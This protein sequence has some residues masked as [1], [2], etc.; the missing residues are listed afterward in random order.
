MCPGRRVVVR[1]E[2]RVQGVGFRFAAVRVARNCAV[3]GYVQNLSS[4]RVLL[5]VEGKEDVLTRFLESMRQSEVGQY[6][7]REDVAWENAT[8]EFDSFTVRY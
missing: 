3:A 5:L 6:I 8:R 2:G 7:V 4:G 1:Y